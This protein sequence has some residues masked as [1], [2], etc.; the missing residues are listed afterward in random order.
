MKIAILD[1]WLEC[2]MDSCDWNRL[3]ADVT[4]DVFHDT[5]AGPPLSRGYNPM[6]SSA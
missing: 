4:I 2:A 3:G 1:D 6:I 5:I